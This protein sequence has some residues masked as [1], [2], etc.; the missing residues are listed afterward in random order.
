MALIDAFELLGLLAGL[1]WRSIVPVAIGIGGALAIYYGSGE[2]PA[3]AAVAFA[4]GF[5]GIC[6]GAVWE[7]A[8]GRRR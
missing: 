1:T 2:T 8:H 4:V 5:T 6:I 3:S 7:F